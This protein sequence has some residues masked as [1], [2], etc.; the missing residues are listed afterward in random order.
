M[1]ATFRKRRSPIPTALCS[2]AWFVFYLRPEAKGTALV[3]N[4]GNDQ[5]PHIFGL[6]KRGE[7]CVSTFY[8]QHKR[9]QSI[10]I[11]SDPAKSHQVHDLNTGKP[12]VVCRTYRGFRAQCTY[13][14]LS[15][16]DTR[17]LCVR[18]ESKNTRQWRGR[19]EGRLDWLPECFR[20]FEEW[21]ENT[22]IASRKLVQE[23]LDKSVECSCCWCKL[24]LHGWLSYRCWRE[25]F[26]WTEQSVIK[27]SWGKG[28]L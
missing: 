14:T 19:T 1:N 6:L 9:N 12:L 10:L 4:S 17:T 16:V 20:A 21:R 26:K 5:F 28:F 8:H 11:A 13:S 22:D 27:Y 25:Y 18:I 2:T 15:R 7:I 23:R 3:R 24:R